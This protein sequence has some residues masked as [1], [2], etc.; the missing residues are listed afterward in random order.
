MNLTTEQLV[1]LATSFGE[2]ARACKRIRSILLSVPSAVPPLKEKL[3]PGT[4]VEEGE[5]SEES[6][7][8]LE[9]DFCES[10]L[11][12]VKGRRMVWSKKFCV[13]YF[14]HMVRS[15]LRVN[16]LK[17]CW[18]HTSGSLEDRGNWKKISRRKAEEVYSKIYSGWEEIAEYIRD[19]K[20]CPAGVRPSKWH[21][22]LEVLKSQMPSKLFERKSFKYVLVDNHDELP[23]LR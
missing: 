22:R 23:S 20:S 11:D 14:T 17:F 21:R 4:T 15:R 2:V 7:N 10:A 1:G 19:H 16:S 13:N 3:P 6:D 18:A 9:E 12:Y 5:Q 8:I